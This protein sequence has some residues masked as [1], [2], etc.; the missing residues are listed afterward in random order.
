MPHPLGV[1]VEGSM[2]S[3][4]F[5]Q[6]SWPCPIHDQHI[7]AGRWSR[8]D[9]LVDAICRDHPALEPLREGIH[10]FLTRAATAHEQRRAHAKYSS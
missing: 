9:E 10:E 6:V 1:V 2:T 8:L 3:P 7:Y 5:V 4:D